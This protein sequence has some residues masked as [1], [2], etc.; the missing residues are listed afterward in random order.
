MFFKLGGLSVDR[1]LIEKRLAVHCGSLRTASLVTLAPECLKMIRLNLG[2]QHSFGRQQMISKNKESRRIWFVGR[3][4]GMFIAAVAVALLAGQLWAQSDNGSIVGTVTDSTG[5]AIPNATIIVTDQATNRV[6]SVQSQGDGTY[7]VSAL[8]I[9][10]YKVEVAK[11]AFKAESITFSLQISEVKELSFS[12]QVGSGTETVRVT[13]TSPLVDTESSSAG[14]V[15]EG[16]QVVDLPLNG[17]N[18][19]TLALLTPGV[20]RGQ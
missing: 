11:Q 2:L 9:G 13:N 15:I 17:R 14:E 16:R 6:V 18:F 1:D 7:V 19:T 8:P 4:F 12:L 20:S 5:A 3:R 10:N